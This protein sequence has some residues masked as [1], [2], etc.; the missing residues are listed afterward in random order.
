M[1]PRI[2]GGFEKRVNALTTGI[3]VDFSNPAKCSG[4]SKLLVT[5]SNPSPFFIKLCSNYRIS[6]SFKA[7]AKCNNHIITLISDKAGYNAMF[8]VNQNSF[9]GSI[10]LGEHFL[11]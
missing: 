9:A 8:L 2:K 1:W 3:F 6:A 5:H 11:I 4:P 10:N 7:P